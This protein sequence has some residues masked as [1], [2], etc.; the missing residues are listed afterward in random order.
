[1]ATHE[2]IKR[3]TIIE[4]DKI[5]KNPKSY[6]K[7]LEERLSYF[8]D[9][10]M[11]YQYP[12][13]TPVMTNE[14]KAV[15]LECIEYLKTVPPCPNG[16]KGND[17][18]AY[19]AQVHANDIGPRGVTGHTGADGSKMGERIERYTEW[20]V[21]IG[22]NI[23][24]GSTSGDKVIMSLITDDGVPHR[25]HRH[26]I[27]KDCFN[28]VGVGVATHKQFGSVTVLDYAGAMGKP[29]G[30]VGPSC[31]KGKIGANQTYDM[32]DS[33]ADKYS[34]KTN[35]TNKG[36]KVEE[37]EPK[38]KVVK[39]NNG[40]KQDFRVRDFLKDGLNEDQVMEIKE[41]FDLID[42]DKSGEIDTEE[43]K[44]FISNL[45][46][47]AHNETFMRMM[48]DLDADG[49]G[50]IDFGEFLEMMTSKM[51]DR[52][53]REDLYKCF[54]L[55]AGEDNDFDDKITVKHLKKVARQ[56]NENMSEEELQEMIAR[57]DLNK[58]QGVDFEEFYEIMTK[59]I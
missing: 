6:I 10:G 22:E 28:F 19:A 30:K 7:K 31:P 15:I 40:I 53:S 14:G 13:K 3:E 20:D 16:I 2:Q 55:F 29:T 12:G 18:L 41:A 58:D 42:A 47:G 54:K 43:L 23:D 8:R 37:P 34:Q 5:R 24:F 50:Q 21:K 46:I 35:K 48:E 56:L 51:S 45:G 11:I 9:C 52:D 1:M 36:K 32:P 57:A 33:G 49:S 25:G 38:K 44:D 59:K 27:F 39:K 4:H 17:Q 26:N